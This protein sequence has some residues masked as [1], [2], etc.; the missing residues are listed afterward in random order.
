MP[1]GVHSVV[2]RL[3][4]VRV[5]RARAGTQPV[6]GEVFASPTAGVA[7]QAEKRLVATLDERRTCGGLTSPTREATERTKHHG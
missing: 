5:H 3:R 6:T 1:F 4:Q 7:D 2:G